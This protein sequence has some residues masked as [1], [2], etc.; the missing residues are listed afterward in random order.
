MAM[1]AMMLNVS[2]QYLSHH[3]SRVGVA[4]LPG[5]MLYV[6]DVLN[7]RKSIEKQSMKAMEELAGLDD[8][9]SK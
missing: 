4:R 6:T 9:M 2:E 3:V 7:L 8:E 5:D 1:A